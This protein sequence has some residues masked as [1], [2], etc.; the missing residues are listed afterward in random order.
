MDLSELIRDLRYPCIH[1]NCI[2]S[3]QAADALEKLLAE[4]KQ[5]RNE[6]TMQTALAQNGQ[7]AIE[8]NR[9]FLRQITN[10]KAERDAAI[11]D[12]KSAINGELICDFCMYDH[13][14]QGENCDKYADGVGCT[15]ENGK[16]YDW[17]WT[18]MDFNFGTCAKLEDTPCNG[19]FENG[20]SGFEWRGC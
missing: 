5:L 16:Y 8:T 15:D 12:I 1:E 6:L 9:Q 3:Y 18:C 11:E 13:K 17:E 2:A 4:N 14:C 20:M 7:S 10:L 19:C